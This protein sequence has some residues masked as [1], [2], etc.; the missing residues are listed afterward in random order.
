MRMF[1]PSIHPSSRSPCRNPSMSGARLE[2]EL[3]A[4]Y[5]MRRTFA[6]DWRAL[7]AIGQATAPPAS[8]RNC[9]RR[10]QIPENLG[11]T[12]RSIARRGE[13]WGRW[14]RTNSITR[15]GTPVEFAP[16]MPARRHR[17]LF[18]S[19]WAIGFAQESAHAGRHPM[20]LSQAA[21]AEVS[22]RASLAAGTARANSRLL[23]GKRLLLVRAL[24]IEGSLRDRARPRAF[25]IEGGDLRLELSRHFRAAL[26]NNLAFL[27]GGSQDPSLHSPGL[28][29]PVHRAIH[30]GFSPDTAAFLRSSRCDREDQD[31]KTN[32]KPHA[33]LRSRCALGSGDFKKNALNGPLPM[34]ADETTDAAKHALAKAHVCGD[35]IE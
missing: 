4:R 5:P 23:G 22:P 26:L 13:R 9:R 25:A 27:I 35:D 33:R 1:C 17:Q 20:G 8:A 21:C 2:D 24:A 19:L 10:M 15:A 3:S 7:T 16:G 34:Q 6:A 28:H 12:V 31:E 32:G 14:T 30:A 18:R 29:A 11:T